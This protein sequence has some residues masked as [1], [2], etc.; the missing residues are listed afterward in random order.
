MQ[1]DALD[2]GFSDP[3]VQ[4]SYAFRAALNAMARPGTIEE[5]VGGHAPEPLSQAAATLILTLCD[6]ETP[7]YLAGE[8]DSPEI[9]QWIAFH[10]GTPI[11]SRSEAMFALGTWDALGPIHDFPIGT[12]EYPDRSATL[13]VE[14]QSLE[15]S[16]AK[17]SGPGVKD[18]SFLNLPEVNAFA[19]NA[20][21]YPLG[22]DF[23]FTAGNH[24]AAIPRST[25][26]EAP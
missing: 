19:G 3:P 6:H 14:V 26:V 8:H 23:F 20:T 13:I 2:G 11:A 18:V 5:M 9:R 4:S 7:I 25:K 15:P 21:L 12:A 16:G 17:L 24:V 1:T 22:L 10:T